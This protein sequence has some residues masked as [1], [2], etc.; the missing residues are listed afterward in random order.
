VY[1]LPHADTPNQ[2]VVTKLLPRLSIRNLEAPARARRGQAEYPVPNHVV[3]AQDNSLIAGSSTTSISAPPDSHSLDDA[4]PV[5][6][7]FSLPARSSHS[8]VDAY[9]TPP[10]AVSDLHHRPEPRAISPTLRTSSLTSESDTIVQSDDRSTRKVTVCH[11]HGITPRQLE[12]LPAHAVAGR[13]LA[14]QPASRPSSS[15]SDTAHQSPDDVDDSGF[16]GEVTGDPE[17]T[18]DVSSAAAD[19]AARLDYHRDRHLSVAENLESESIVTEEDTMSIKAVQDDAASTRSTST[20]GWRARLEQPQDEPMQEDD[21]ET[22]PPP[23]PTPPFPNSPSSRLAPPASTNALHLPSPEQRQESVV[24]TLTTLG[25][26]GTYQ[27]KQA[28]RAFAFAPTA[29]IREIEAEG[30]DDNDDDDGPPPPLP[31]P[32]TGWQ[33]ID[34]FDGPDIV[35]AQYVMGAE[36]V[37]RAR[38]QAS[39]SEEPTTENPRVEEL[40]EVDTEPV[41][42]ESRTTN[43]TPKTSAS[44]T[45]KKS[46]R[47]A[48]VVSRFGWSKKKGL[49][50]E[51]GASE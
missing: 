50:V 20:A 37:I 46:A 40:R 1:V 34:P 27:A 51:E 30:A 15:G 18:D 17:E 28:I 41:S 31:P 16:G 21:Q 44:G 9:P 24:K 11:E 33:P 14:T 13:M 3:D 2:D 4:T 12:K 7:T 39:S 25:R 47:I 38:A 36:Q 19:A 8:G 23:I 10:Q 22:V 45:L 48:R 35:L 32:L 26:M 6:T 43:S 5:S 29:E 42:G 49:A